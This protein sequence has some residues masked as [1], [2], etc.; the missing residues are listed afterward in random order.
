MI[1]SLSST[2]GPALHHVGLNSPEQSSI[3]K[4]LQALSSEG[5]KHLINWYKTEMTLTVTWTT[6][7]PNISQCGQTL[8]G[9]S[10]FVKC[11]IDSL[12]Q[13]NLC[14]NC[15]EVAEAIKSNGHGDSI[16]WTCKCS[17]HLTDSRAELMIGDTEVQTCSPP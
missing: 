15:V 11:L 7:D 1:N 5:S 17:K 9:A 12:K 6:G 10:E 8:S 14:Q 4:E 13:V 16:T 2:A 3:N